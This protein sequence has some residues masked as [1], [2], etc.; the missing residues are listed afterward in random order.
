MSPNGYSNNGL[1]V[2]G[3]G[4]AGSTEFPTTQAN[5]VFYTFEGSVDAMSSG[6]RKARSAPA[7]ILAARASGPPTFYHADRQS[8][9]PSA[10]GG[11]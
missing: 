2:N 3:G 10:G 8:A 5:S 9:R 1:K 4:A 7:F 6:S 11:A